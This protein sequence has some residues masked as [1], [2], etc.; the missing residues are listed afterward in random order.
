MTD[1]DV[2]ADDV[3]ADDV[4]AEP[5]PGEDEKGGNGGGFFRRFQGLHQKIPNVVMFY[6]MF[7]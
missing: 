4:M 6:V 1:D 7:F 5:L 2:M 3:M